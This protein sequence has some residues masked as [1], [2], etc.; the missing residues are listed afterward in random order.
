MGTKRG[1]HDDRG[2]DSEGGY[3]NEGAAAVSV[4]SAA[5]DRRFK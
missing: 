5:S 2:V 3:S 4:A 1:G